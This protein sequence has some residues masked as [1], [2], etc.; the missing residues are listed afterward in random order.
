[1]THAL[2]TV[3]ESVDKTHPRL[4][5]LIAFGLICVKSKKCLLVIGPPGCGKSIALQAIAKR[6][7]DG[8]R[9]DSITRASLARR[10]ED[11]RNFQSLV[12][13][14]DMGGIDSVYNRHATI[15]TFAKLCYDHFVFKYSADT[16]IEI[17]EFYGSA[18]LNCQ[19]PIMTQLMLADDWESL[20]QDKTVR[21]YHLFR[22]TTITYTVPQFE[23]DDSQDITKV[24]LVK[25]DDGYFELLMDLGYSQ[26]SDARCEEHIG[27][28]LRS[29]AA[30]DGRTVTDSSDY[31]LLLELM[32]SVSIERYLATKYELDA[33]R[34]FNSNLLA[35]IIE[36][37]SWQGLTVKR[38]CRDYKCDPATVVRV[39]EGLRDYFVIGLESKDS[40][41]IMPKAKA[42]LDELGISIAAKEGE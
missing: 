11:F 12:I 35:I 15:S 28:F 42:I 39:I 3:I 26:W 9:A 4:G 40:I 7:P 31:D 18:I 24:E 1:M 16:K 19:P 22:P 41:T 29:C 38:I 20:S 34:H 25:P 21:Y 6:Y 37:A 33:D 32:P 27:G 36:L 2:R 30:W 23:I 8:I 10:Q 17:D 5:S 14:D 13:I